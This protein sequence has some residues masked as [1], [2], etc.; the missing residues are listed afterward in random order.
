MI[1]PTEPEHSAAE[2]G[3]PRA[4]AASSRTAV[5]IGF[6]VLAVAAHELQWALLPFVIAG[7]LAFVATPL[8]EQM[9]ALLGCP[10]AAAAVA[11]FVA[12]ISIAAI[13]GALGGPRLVDE[14]WH[15]VSELPHIVTIL[16][17]NIMGD[18]TIDLFGRSM[19]ATQLAQ[20][21][22]ADLRSLLGHAEPLTILGSVAYAAMFGVILV[23]VLLFYFLVNGPRLMRGLLWL[24]PP[25]RQPML[26]E[27]CLNLDPVLKRYI[28]GMMIVLIYATTAAYIGLGL[29]LGIRHAVLLAL[30]TGLLETVPV[31]GPALS[32]IVG[33]IAA[34]RYASGVGLILGYAIYA[35]A[36]RISIDQLLG[37][38]VLGAAARL[39]PTV[40]IFCLLSGGVL[41]GLV[42]VILA[43]P[44]ALTVRVSLSV[45]RQ[46][47]LIMHAKATE[48]QSR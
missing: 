11:V 14:L 24:A 18:R 32:I 34:I 4:E 12:F 26:R 40:I 29:V 35:T 30:L 21:A 2:V 23:L 47:P 37:P 7:L 44:V 41:F 43:V 45:L 8:V 5:Y 22:I 48:R 42:G 19:N 17:K 28:V 9:T 36:L 38:I 10:R 3:A 16:A 6:A 13:I 15:F 39:H 1:Q 25:R 33:G 27:I 31:A 20:A 46:E